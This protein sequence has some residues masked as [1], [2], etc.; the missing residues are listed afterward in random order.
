M[1]NSPAQNLVIATASPSTALARLSPGTARVVLASLFMLIAL[2]LVVSLSSLSQ[3]FADQPNRGPGDVALYRCEVDRL[4]AGESYYPVAAEELRARG[5]PTKSVFNWRT[6]L[7]MSLLGMFPYEAVGRVL[8]GSLAGV[9]LLL[10]FVFMAREG[11]T[12]SGLLGA[13]L[14]VGALLPCWLAG[15][16]VMP[17]L[18]AGSLIAISVFACGVG[19]TKLGVASGIAALFMRDLAG[20]Y[21]AFAWCYAVWRKQWKE[22]AWWTA[23]LVAYAGFF[24]WHIA[25][26]SA[27]QTGSDIAHEQ[28]WLRLGGLSFLISITQ[29]NG[30]LLNLPQWVAAIYLPLAMLGLASLSSE[31]GQ[32]AALATLMYVTLFAVVGQPINQYWG[33]LIAPL[34][35]LGAA[36][37]PWAMRDLWSRAKLPSRRPTPVN[38]PA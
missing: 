13:L 32:R 33:S 19:R 37:A 28:G 24:A 35:C 11:G 9:A 2:S 22:A 31:T 23:G 29:M 38:Q 4:R 36:R 25:Q 6:P 7:P 30:F 27:L 5:Y 1:S 34:L 10:G 20:P 3:G 8:L 17:M 12:G 18:W 21:C 15:L 26:V 14:L 16:V